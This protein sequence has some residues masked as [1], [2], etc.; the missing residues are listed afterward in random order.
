MSLTDTPSAHRI[1]QLNDRLRYTL[2]SGGQLVLTTGF[3]SLA[4][5][6]QVAFLQALRRYHDFTPDNDP[7]DEHDFG[8]LEQDGVRVLWMIDYYD[9]SL[10]YHSPDPADP[11]Q[12]RR[13][14]TV[15]L[16]EEY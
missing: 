8:A 1:R 6:R 14:L 4:P 16:A 3:Q 10:R 2:V 5:A 13:I 11:A 9:L 15:M 7:Y 12:T